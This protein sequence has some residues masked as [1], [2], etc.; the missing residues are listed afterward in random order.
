MK[1]LNDG[2]A[3]LCC[4]VLCCAVL[5]CAVLCCAV[6][7]CCSGSTV[8]TSEYVTPNM[9]CVYQVGLF[10]ENNSAICGMEPPLTTPADAVNVRD[11][12]IAFQ[13][14]L[15]L[16]RKLLA[17]KGWV[18][19]CVVCACVYGDLTQATSVAYSLCNQPVLWP[20]TAL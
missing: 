6:L 2:H 13:C 8:N 17:E 3:V 1:S 20:R 5:C 19:W 12:A 7:C 18:C 15:P 9:L 10:K 14:L 11:G 4:T 16:M